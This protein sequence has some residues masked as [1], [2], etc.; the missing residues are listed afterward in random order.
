MGI[1]GL[2]RAF[3]ATPALGNRGESFSTPM[4]ETD[5]RGILYPSSLFDS[6]AA[7]KPSF[8]AFK[9]GTINTSGPDARGFVQ[10]TDDAGNVFLD[11]EVP[12]GLGGMEDAKGMLSMKDLELNSPTRKGTALD[13]KQESDANACYAY[14]FKG[15]QPGEVCG[16]QI[17]TQGKI[18]A[19]V[20]CTIA[21]HKT[22]APLID[23]TYYLRSRDGSNL[24][25]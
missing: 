4:E 3:A 2:A 21:S 8:V 17:G 10:L 24:W 19:L 1:R 7:K 25:R 23:N 6:P 5:P 22:K 15:W 11:A 16:G 9:A 18:C 12:P 14:L 20:G 13:P